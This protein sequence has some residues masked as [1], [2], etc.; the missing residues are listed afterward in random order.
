MVIF[1]ADFE[2]SVIYLIKK[3]NI[4]LIWIAENE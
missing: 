2:R 4:M 1:W 3:K